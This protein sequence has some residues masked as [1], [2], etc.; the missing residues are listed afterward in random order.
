MAAVAADRN[1]LFGLLALQNG[2][3][4]QRQ[5]V[6][7]FQAWT[8]DRACALAD[9]LIGCGDLD[10]D[11]RAGVEAMVSLHLK[12]HGGSA[13]KSLAAIPAGRS[14]RESLAALADPVIDQ[15][16]TQLASGSDGDADRTAIYAVGTATSSGQRFRVLRPHARGGL[17]AVFVALD[18]ELHREVV[19]KQILESHADD[20]TSRQ[21]FLL[22]AEVTGGLEHPGIVPV[23]G[24][25]TYG[26]GRPYYA[27]RFIRGDSLKEAIE[28]FHAGGCP[29]ED[30][31]GQSL[32]LRKL[33]RRLL[34]VCNAIEY[35]HSRGVLHRDIK[36]GNIIVGR[37][38]ETLVVDWGLAKA[39]GRAEPGSGER[40]LLPNSA[41]GSTDTLPGAALGTPAYMSPEQARGELDR[42]GS[43]S[44]VYSL[45][46]TLYC[47]LTGK[48]PFHG[49]DLGRAL[50]L[51]QEGRYDAPRRLDPSIDRS[52]EAICLKAMALRPEDRYVSAQDLAEDLDRWLADE[53]VSAWREP[54][55]AR[56]GRWVRRHRSG[57]VGAAAAS[58]VAI[59]GLTV[60]VLL[61]TAANERERQARRAADIQKAEALAQ[62]D[63]A[64]RN[65][66]LAREAVDR[67]L[68]RVSE[69]D[70]LKAQ[71]LE[72]LRRDLLETAREFYDRF[73]EQARDDPGLRA[74]Q[75][76]AYGRL[77]DI[78]EQV[79]VKAEAIAL[80]DRARA[81]FEDLTRDFPA[82]AGYWAELASRLNL[83]GVLA[84]ETGRKPEAEAAYKQ[85]K[86]I[87]QRQIR[88]HPDDS[89]SVIGLIEAQNNLGLLWD[90]TGRN[91]EA[92]AAYQSAIAILGR[93][94]AGDPEMQKQR[95][96][97]SALHHNLGYL[98]IRRDR[99]AEAQAALG[100]AIRL[101]EQWVRD[102][103]GLPNAAHELAVSHDNLAWSYVRTARHAEAERHY[104]AALKLRRALVDQH[105]D[106]PEYRSH[107]V[108]SHRNT[109]DFYRRI[110]RV[111]DAE[112]AYRTAIDIG[113]RL[114]REHPD[115]AEY[116]NELASS[117]YLLG[118]LDYN[119][120]RYRDSEAEYLRALEDWRRLS[121][122]HPEF[123]DYRA[124]L[125]WTHN[126]LALVCM[127]TGRLNEERANV[128]AAMEIRRR[129]AREHPETP[130]FANDLAASHN[131]L[132]AFHHRGQRFDE[133]KKSYHAALA[134][135]Q[136]LTEER[137]DVAQYRHE[138]AGT[139]AN[140]GLVD[141][142]AGRLDE[143]EAPYRAALADQERLAREHPE[144]PEYR[145]DLAKYTNEL[146]RLNRRRGRLDE[147]EAACRT[148]LALAERLSRERPGDVDDAVALGEVRIELGLL[149]LRRGRPAPALERSDAALEGLG[150]LL[151]REPKMDEAKQ[152]VA[153]AAA[154]RARALDRLGRPREAVATWDG[155]LAAAADRD[156]PRL[157]ALRAASLA[158]AGDYRQAIAAVECEAA[159][160]RPASMEL[161]K[162]LACAH[163]QIAAAILRSGPSDP[164]DRQAA[165]ERHADLAVRALSR[166]I[167]TGALRRSEAT[168]VLGSE[169]DLDPLRSGPGF[170]LLI[171]DLFMPDDPF[172]R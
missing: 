71:A 161:D 159:P 155:A 89:R 166:A 116:R 12:K 32:E 135:R 36:P 55:P 44:D 43:R 98:N 4:N 108:R 1:L 148:A 37:Y 125:A 53:P 7:A 13:E 15:T 120:A 64:E 77:A 141:L 150:D 100:E 145:S 105:P 65:F 153:E 9:H 61:L 118:W 27:M 25:G 132:G 101:R 170:R 23:Y 95:Y 99:H 30:A 42:L 75:G 88:E 156:R 78:T 154:V 122:K 66:R 54:L 81:I 104:Q 62:R 131:N 41:S 74:E 48:P 117:H 93:L 38:G 102:R 144:V 67:Y 92:E 80:N 6:A 109:G 26:D 142:D 24:L 29:K 151:R 112:A 140:L 45:G 49:D 113:E 21:R 82:E 121:Q 130:G 83:A 17:G 20:P 127:R 60:G 79:G 28:Q 14:T 149:D 69:D 31:G 171:M 84:Y 126:D 129:L 58:L 11:Q 152:L 146:G 10:A 158:R 139:R 137:P 97:F 91:D 70:R 147:A 169:P 8:L 162:A 165:G 143:A 18:T 56:A 5:L 34:D 164:S 73:L 115:V 63:R 90:E 167:A 68:T 110:G 157:Q 168:E 59:A 160:G 103:P 16:L 107:L 72:P 40:T 19:L 52:L 133:A 128:E 134:I 46:A 111:P 124:R 2:L 47:I 76:R 163:A 106:I 57:V 50:K 51:V 85:A 136:R 35:A 87:R 22:E 96:R 39:T 114:V 33:L 123:V 86:E 138:L 172:A 94:P 119:L 3:I